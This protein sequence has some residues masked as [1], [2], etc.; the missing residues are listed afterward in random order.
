ML[1]LEFIFCSWFKLKYLYTKHF[2]CFFNLKNIFTWLDP[3]TTTFIDIELYVKIQ[4]SSINYF[5][6]ESSCC[7]IWQVSTKLINGIQVRNTNF[8]GMNKGILLY[9]KVGEVYFKYIWYLN[10]EIQCE[11][12]YHFGNPRMIKYRIRWT[13]DISIILSLIILVMDILWNCGI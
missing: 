5:V 12:I 6:Q 8:A 3:Y 10:I 1:M 7:C 13:L 9:V 4:A 2:H 11:A